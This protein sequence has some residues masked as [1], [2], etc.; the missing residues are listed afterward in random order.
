MSRG[1]SPFPAA[2]ESLSEAL[3]YGDMY[4]VGSFEHSWPAL[5]PIKTGYMLVRFQSDSNTKP[6]GLVAGFRIRIFTT[7][8]DSMR[9]PPHYTYHQPS[10]IRLLHRLGPERVEL[11]PKVGCPKKE[12]DH[13]RLQCCGWN[14]TEIEDQYAKILGATITGMMED[15]SKSNVIINWTLTH[16][17]GVAH[18]VREQTPPYFW[19][20]IVDVTL[21]YAKAF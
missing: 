9:F 18:L 3:M 15:M 16:E 20:E 6:A 13:V 19:W 8:N 11:A 17:N 14:R 7:R 4:S 21:D 5:P 2:G 1:R 12:G 10:E